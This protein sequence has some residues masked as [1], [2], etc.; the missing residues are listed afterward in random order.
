MR[1]ILV[2]GLTGHLGKNLAKNLNKYFYIY[3]L[4]RRTYFNYKNI[5]EIKCDLGKESEKEIIKKIPRGIDTILY[6]AQSEHYKNF[7]EK[8]EDIFKINL[9]VPFWLL[10]YSLKNNVKKFLYTSTGE[11]KFSTKKKIR[12]NNFYQNTKLS[13]EKL[14]SNF[15][16][17]IGVSILRMFYLYSN[18]ENN[19]LVNSLCKKINNNQKITLN[20]SKDGDLI[21]I[22]HAE[23]CANFITHIMRKNI[24]DFFDLA[25]ERR[26]SIR[27]LSES[28]AKKMNKNV[29]FVIN[30]KEETSETKVN[31]DKIRKYT[32]RN[33]F[34]DPEIGLKGLYLSDN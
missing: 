16:K 30:K 17:Y 1:K 29:E 22:T 10:Q 6:L 19:G 12:N 3:S 27:R 33:K 21:H 7:P 24:S 32:R 2:T 28:I 18:V 15:D 34:R 14:I 25:P 13:F 20:G 5:K 23:D 8:N 9:Q 11:I 31:L 4:Q 26:I